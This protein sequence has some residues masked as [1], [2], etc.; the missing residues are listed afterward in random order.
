MAIEMKITDYR[1]PA[2]LGF[3]LIDN[4]R[5]CAGR[6]VIV[7]RYAHQFRAGF[8]QQLYLGDRGGDISGIGVGHRL[9]HDWCVTADAD[10]GNVD[11]MSITG[12]V[13]EILFAD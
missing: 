2:I 10:T 5:H 6:G 11:A 13:H 8:V 12:L 9:H 1:Y 4:M 7:H 3:K